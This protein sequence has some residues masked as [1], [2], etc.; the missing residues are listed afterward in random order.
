MTRL[1]K[2][3]FVPNG[4]GFQTYQEKISEAYGQSTVT[5]RIPGP[6]AYKKLVYPSAERIV[7][8]ITLGRKVIVLKRIKL[9]RRAEYNKII[10]FE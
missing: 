10:K 4:V 8:S 9:S 2:D 6:C 3:N 5:K 7:I 1:F